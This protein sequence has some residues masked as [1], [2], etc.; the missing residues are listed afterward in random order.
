[1]DGIKEY[2]KVRIKHKNIVGR[3]ID[4]FMD[5]NGKTYYDVESLTPGYVDDPDAYPG[6]W[7]QYTCT[8]DQ[9]ELIS[10]GDLE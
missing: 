5:S 7:P 3:V 2:D 6:Y 1:M 9:L 4:I 10:S 8:E